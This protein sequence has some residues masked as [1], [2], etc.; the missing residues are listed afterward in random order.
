[1]ALAGIPAWQDQTLELFHGTSD[2]F[3]SSIQK[4]VDVRKGQH[5]KDFGRG[6]Y[7]TTNIDKA[8]DWAANTA[9]FVGGDPAVVRFEVSR[10]DLAMLDCLF[11]VR[12]DKSA[13]DFWSFVQ[14]CRTIPSDHNRVHQAW[15]D[16]VVG[17]I[18]GTWT[19][20]SVIP[21][22]DQI[23]FHTRHAT[24]VLDACRKQVV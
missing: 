17:P 20:Q 10:N 9:Y 21:D 19:Q 15:Y 24:R 11:F 7:T 4:K 18:T 14:Y 5:L 3:L 8:R 22:A 12:G 6:F 23:S 2:L 16:L 13:V 1:M